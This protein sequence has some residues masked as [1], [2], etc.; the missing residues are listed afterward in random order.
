M[1][2]KVLPQIKEQNGT[3]RAD[4]HLPDAA[5]APPLKELPMPPKTL[6][7]DVYEVWYVQ[8]GALMD[9]KI[10]SS[11]DLV[12]LE[13]FCNEKLRYDRAGAALEN[14]E[15]IS[16]TNGGS[17]SMVNLHIRIQNDAL[18]NMLD[19]S[20]RFGFDPLSRMDVGVAK[21]DKNDP[22]KKLIK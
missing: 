14:E 18:K 19:I 12:L 13:A 8:A 20:K 7:K 5:T 16:K 10:L 22:V 17:T 9:M 2:R 21:S 4:R 6:H 3:W 15:M 1:S 11:A